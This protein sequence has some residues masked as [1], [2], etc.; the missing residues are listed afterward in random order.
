MKITLPKS[1]KAREK[2]DKIIVAADN[3]FYE[4]GYNKA[5]VADITSAADVAV[6]TFYLY[7]E[8]KLSLYHYILFDYQTR[9][10]RYINDRMGNVK[11]RSEKER[12]GLIAWLEFVNNNPHTYG[13]IWQSIDVDKTL[14]VDYY[15]K[16]AK[17]Y[18]KGLKIDED[19]II[20]VNYEDLALMLMG[21]SS[22][23]GLK[24]MIHEGKKLTQEEIESMAD[25]M[26]KILKNGLFTI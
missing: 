14:F 21:I 16:F 24:V 12:I 15:S 22:F 9:I 7:F 26:M 5:S 25:S 8:D 18:E 13:I 1:K 3:L 11:T 19:Q 6:G 20:D 17:S 10:K 2:F 23:L 4:R